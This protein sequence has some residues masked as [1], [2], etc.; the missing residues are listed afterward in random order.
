MN[1]KL[2]IISTLLLTTFVLQAQKVTNVQ[3]DQEG[4]QVVITY[5]LTGRIANIGVSFSSNGGTT[6]VPL[7]KVNGDVGERI[8]PGRHV[9]VWN[10]AEEMGEI[11]SDQVVIRVDCSRATP[12]R[13]TFVLFNGS[14]NL[15]PQ[16]AMGFTV[17]QVKKVGWYVSLLTNGNLFYSSD[18]TADNRGYVNGV[19]PMYADDRQTSLLAANAGL[20]IRLCEPAW[21][22]LGVGYGKRLF[23]QQTLDDKWI[24]QSA[25]LHE[26]VS[27]DAGVMLALNKFL[28]SGGAHSIGLDYWEIKVGIGVNF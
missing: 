11:E 12:L 13:R 3:F 19:Y 23:M 17:G 9:V 5:E 2:I 28:L 21:I 20:T 16:F 1:K 6:Y 24:L 27:L 4:S 10:A 26:G 8:E 25:G 18:Y 7:R 22:Y 15:A 14:Y